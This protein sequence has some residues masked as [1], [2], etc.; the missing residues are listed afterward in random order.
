MFCIEF[1]L[2]RAANGCLPVKL[3]LRSIKVLHTINME[4]LGKAKDTSVF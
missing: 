3:V 2:K 1:K 4:G